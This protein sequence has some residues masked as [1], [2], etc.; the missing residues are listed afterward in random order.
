MLLMLKLGTRKVGNEIEEV[1]FK[2]NSL[3]D[4]LENE[5]ELYK[6]KTIYEMIGDHSK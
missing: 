3:K 2:E 6:E 1:V 4:S 5:T